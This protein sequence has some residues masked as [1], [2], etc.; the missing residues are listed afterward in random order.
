MLSGI[1]GTLI[2]LVSTTTGVC[3][4]APEHHLGRL[5]A[6]LKFG[7]FIQCTMSYWYEF[8]CDFVTID[9]GR[10]EAVRGL[11]KS[12]LN[13]HFTWTPVLAGPQPA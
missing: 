13:A 3:I 10:Y 1:K 12:T 8:S 5:P 4:C 7:V 6:A 9:Y 11:R 2:H